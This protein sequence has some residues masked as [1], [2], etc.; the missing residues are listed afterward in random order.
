MSEGM[1]KAL[2]AQNTICECLEGLD[3]QSQRRIITSVCS[4]LGIPLYTVDPDPIDDDDGDDE[5]PGY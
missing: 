4:L 3:D 2:R 5:G 1:E